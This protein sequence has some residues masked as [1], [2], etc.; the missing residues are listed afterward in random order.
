MIRAL[1]PFAFAAASLVLAGCD[2]GEPTVHECETD[3]DCPQNGRCVSSAE[4]SVLVCASECNVALP[5]PLGQTCTRDDATD[6]LVCL[7]NIGTVS[8]GEECEYDFD[9]LSGA[10]VGEEGGRFCTELCNADRSCD[11]DAKRCF[12]SDGKRVCLLP[13]GDAV[14]GE[15]CETPTE[16]ASALCTASPGE[17]DASATCVPE[18]SVESD[19][20]EGFVCVETDIGAF[21]CVKGSEVGAPCNGDHVC[22]SGICLG[23]TDTCIAG[24]EDYL[25]DDGF[26]CV[27]LTSGERACAPRT[28]DVAEGEPCESPRDCASGYCINF[29]TDA[30]SFGTLCADAC[31]D[32]GCPAERVC[33]ETDQVDVCGPI[34]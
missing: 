27:T 13:T 7:E 1:A 16:C 18:C 19:C 26:A 29:D 32:A 20:L 8:D 6:N 22:L 9:C 3:A 11:D 10:C 14:V 31:P 25:C 12:V 33:W 23:E 24:C 30:Q 34:P 17:P 4:S 15:A 21:A 28:D 5:C 2:D